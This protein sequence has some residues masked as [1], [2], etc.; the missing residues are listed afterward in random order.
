L[1]AVLLGKTAVDGPYFELADK[2]RQELVLTL[3]KKGV[4]IS[5]IHIDLKAGNVNVSMS[6]SKEADRHNER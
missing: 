4:N 3:K 6:I 1:E 5:D 2:I